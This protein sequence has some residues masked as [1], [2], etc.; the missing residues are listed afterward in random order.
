M[1]IPACKPSTLEIKSEVLYQLRLQETPAQKNNFVVDV[2]DVIYPTPCYTCKI[3]ASVKHIW[4]IYG[5]HSVSNKYLR[6]KLLGHS[7]LK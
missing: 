4:V 2:F 7:H 5:F 3:L 1:A 6:V